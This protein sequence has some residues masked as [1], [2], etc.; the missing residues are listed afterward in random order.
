MPSRKMVAESMKDKRKRGYSRGN[1]NPADLAKLKDRIATQIEMSDNAIS[2]LLDALK[3]D[4][5]DMGIKLMLGSMLNHRK[6]LDGVSASLS[7]DG[8][9][10]LV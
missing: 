1:T 3:S 8:K 5:N 2:G 6:E 10:H 9:P 4:P 7:R